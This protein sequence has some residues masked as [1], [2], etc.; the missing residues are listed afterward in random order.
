LETMIKRSKN[1]GFTLIEMLVAVGVFAIAAVVS[2]GALLNIADMER[3]SEA[4]RAVNDNINFSLEMMMREIRAGRA[5]NLSSGVF[6]FINN[7]GITIYYRLNNNRIERSNDGINY[8]SI[9]SP[10]LV[11]NNLDF[12]LR[13][14]NAND[15]LQPMVIISIKGTAGLEKQNTKTNLNLQTTVTQRRLDS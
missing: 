9:T 13:G 11:V 10:E 14:A 7:E 2:L 8:K 6:S 1:R 3:K 5:Y 15:G 4:L 12:T